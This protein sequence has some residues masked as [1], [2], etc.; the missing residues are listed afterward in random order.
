M[1]ALIAR[2]R[3]RLRHLLVFLRRWYFDNKLVRRYFRR[4]SLGDRGESVAERYLRRHRL[5]IVARQVRDVFGE[6]DL[7]AID[8]RTVVFIEVKTRRSMTASDALSAVNLEKQRR[9][10][11]SALRFMRRNDLL[12]CA[13]RF[14]VVAV[15]WPRRQRRP[16]IVHVSNAFE[17]PG[18]HSMF[19]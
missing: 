2:W 14:D 13:A 7:I 19:G 3:S 17:M 15:I 11:H 18:E 6:I 16:E 9:I 5:R 12:Q 10:S 1:A 8:G 4:R